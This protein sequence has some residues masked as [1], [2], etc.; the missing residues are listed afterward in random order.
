METLVLLL[1][2]L[3]LVVTLRII[4]PWSKEVVRGFQAVI[5]FV[6]IA[7]FLVGADL[8]FPLPFN[9]EALAVVVL[10]TAGSGLT[11]VVF[12]KM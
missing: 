9:A 4:R 10:F 8:L 12:R 11:L 7:M 5:V 2:L 3:V 6:D 1:A